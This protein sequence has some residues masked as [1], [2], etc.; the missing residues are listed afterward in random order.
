MHACPSAVTSADPALHRELPASPPG[1]GARSAGPRLCRA[2]LLPLCGSAHRNATPVHCAHR[3][4]LRPPA[5]RLAP[6]REGAANEVP[7]AS[8]R[9]LARLQAAKG[10][11]VLRR[12]PV[13]DAGRAQ[14]GRHGRLRGGLGAAARGLARPAGRRTSRCRRPLPVLPVPARLR[15]GT[16]RRRARRASVPRGARRG[17]ARRARGRRRAAA[18]RAGR[19]GSV[20]VAARAR[21]RAVR[22]R[23]SGTKRGVRPRAGLRRRGRQP[24]GISVALSRRGRALVRARRHLAVLPGR[25]SQRAPGPRGRHRPRRRLTLP[26]AVLRGRARGVRARLRPSGPERAGSQGHPRPTGRADLIAQAPHA[27]SCSRTDR[28]VRYQP[29]AMGVS[30]L[31]C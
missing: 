2:P 8:S 21:R 23:W 4:A 27:S 29:P 1:A 9:N 31:W 28:D 10:A 22:G 19:A 18:A 17:R 26:S 25:R 11:A 24:R 14:A 30:Q 12:R 15:L 13:A 5:A 20:H 3:Y 16:H 7:A 6:P